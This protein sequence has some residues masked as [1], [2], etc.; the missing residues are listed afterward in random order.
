MNIISCTPSNISS[1]AL[2]IA[3]PLAIL[4]LQTQ[5]LHAA[6][7]VELTDS[8]LE[9]T[10]TAN[11]RAQEV[12]DTLSAI[13]VISRSEIEKTQATSLAEVLTRVPGINISNSGGLGKATS[14]FI[15]GTNSGQLLVLVDG[16]R[17]GSATLGTTSFQHIPVDQIERIEVVRGSR[18]SIYGSDAVGGVIQVFTRKGKQGFQPSIEVA[19]GS[20]DTFKG[21]VN[22]SGGNERT[23]YNLSAQSLK[24]NG[25]DACNSATSGCFADEPDNDG[26]ENNSVSLN[27]SHSFSDILKGQLTL[28]HAEGENDFDGGFQNESEFVQQVVNAQLSAD[29]SDKLNLKFS[30]GRSLDESDNFLDGTFTG[31]FDTERNTASVIADYSVNDSN[32]F[33]FGADFYDSIVDSNTDYDITSRNNTGVFASYLGQFNKTQLNVSLRNDD[34]EQFGSE[35]TGGITIGQNISDSITVRASYGTA[36]NAPTFNQ[37]YFP[38]FGNADLLPEESQNVEIGIEGR[39]GQSSWGINLFQNDIDNLIAG[40]PVSNVDEARIRGIEGI[41]KA[42]LGNYDLATNVTL[43]KPEA[44]SGDNE[45]KILRSRPRRILNVDLDRKFNRFSLGAT[46]HAES[47]RFSDAGN[48]ESLAGF[49]RL[50]LRAEYDVSKNWT[51]GLKVENAL[52]KEYSLNEGFNQDGASGLLT[53]KYSPK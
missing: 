31:N 3:I 17:H 7:G 48:S 29:V 12:N 16:V 24:T 13:T 47:E 34:N 27:L 33:L 10:V 5:A 19:G 38:G 18:S 22:L 52:D 21:V 28:L 4:S 1:F 44:R 40:F 43:Q 39:Y 20:N 50:D 53:I 37:L 41:Y 30:V 26:Y 36:F 35:T 45:G 6:D 9:L 51:V 14:V 15:R 25:I 42:T 11:R 8:G 49:A 46:L 32:S 2:K 23:T